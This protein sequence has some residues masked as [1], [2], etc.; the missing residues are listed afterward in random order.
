MRVPHAVRR[1]TDPLL[2]RLRVPVLSGVNRGRWWSI[3]SAGSGYASG[4][5]A[6]PQ[7]ELLM[8]LL[9][10]GDVVWDVGAHH[11][12]VTLA[13]ARRVGPAGVVHAFE[14]SARNRRALR[15]HVRWNTERAGG[16][17]VVVH[18]F[19]LGDHDGE[20]CF[21]G[22][23]TSKMYALGGGAETV[24]VR[25]ADTLV[26]RGVC[27]PPTFVKLDV[28]GGEADAISGALSVLSPSA[29]LLIAVHGAE[30][31]ARC[32]ALLRDAGFTLVASRALEQCR[33]GPW[34]ADPD[35]F[36]IG[37]ESETREADLELLRTAGF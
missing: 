9:R 1:V 32:T 22:S 3:T 24:A 34:H 6:G 37:P 27:P 2:G 29:R 16:E 5:R 14:P 20:A 17:N 33:R 10:P 7:M 19:A 4:R 15:R 23:G 36:A 13:A 30:V 11:G 35:F 18:P 26:A 12:F 8:A 31:G 21:G 25:R 28:E